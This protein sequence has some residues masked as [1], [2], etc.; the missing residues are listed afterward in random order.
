MHV[1]SAF[2]RLVLSASL[3]AFHQPATLQDRLRAG[4]RVGLGTCGS[5]GGEAS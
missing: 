2:F 1:F 4:P 3:G 5:A